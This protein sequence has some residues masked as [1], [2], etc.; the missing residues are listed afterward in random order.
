M[1]MLICMLTVLAPLCACQSG[2]KKAAANDSTTAASIAP[3]EVPVASS[4]YKQYKGRLAGQ[5]ITLQLV[6]YAPGKYEGWYVYDKVGKPIGISLSRETADSL[7]F[8][9]YAGADNENMFAGI[10]TGGHYRGQWSGNDKTFDFDLAEDTDSVI[11]F[12]T[13]MFQDSARLRPD[14]PASPGQRPAP[15]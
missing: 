14:D 9:E 12:E 8:A 11:T 2:Q 15:P 10:F 7:F 5:P 4:F 1:R 13:F 3:V 6:K